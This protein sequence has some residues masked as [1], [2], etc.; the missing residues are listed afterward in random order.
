LT[1]SYVRPGNASAGV[2]FESHT[3]DRCPNNKPR[4]LMGTILC[5]NATGTLLPVVEDPS[6]TYNII[7]TSPLVCSADQVDAQAEE[8]MKLAEKAKAMYTKMMNKK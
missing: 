4:A 1:W 6:C 3:G 8:H 5:G 7:L 2:R